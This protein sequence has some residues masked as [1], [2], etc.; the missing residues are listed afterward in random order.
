M[1]K[2]KRNNKNKDGGT[3]TKSLNHRDRKRGKHGEKDAD[4]EYKD[5]IYDTRPYMGLPSD[6][7]REYG[8]T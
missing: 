5:Q 3:P 1:T 2:G 7:K 4:G 8:L 6:T